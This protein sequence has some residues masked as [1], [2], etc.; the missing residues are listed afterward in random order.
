MARWQS[1]GLIT[2]RSQV[3]KKVNALE[4]FGKALIVISNSLWRGLEDVG[5]LVTY[6]KAYTS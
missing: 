5:P 6:L 3:R 2:E 1:S 4:P